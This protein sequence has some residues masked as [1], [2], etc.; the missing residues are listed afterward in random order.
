MYS[1]NRNFPILVSEVVVLHKLEQIIITGTV[2][3]RIPPTRE[4]VK[5]IKKQKLF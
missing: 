4:V 3:Q 1:M 5:F 2:H